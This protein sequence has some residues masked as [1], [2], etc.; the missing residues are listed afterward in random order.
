MVLRTEYLLTPIGLFRSNSQQ[1]KPQSIIRE[2]EVRG[3]DLVYARIDNVDLRGELSIFDFTT[4]FKQAGFTVEHDF[5]DKWKGTLKIGASDSDFVEPRETTLQVDRLN[6][7]GL[8]LR[9]PR[10]R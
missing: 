5:N 9:L 1:G 10:E 4:E 6:T 7:R 3:N 2:A 8:H